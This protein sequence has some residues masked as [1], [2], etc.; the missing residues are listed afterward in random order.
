MPLELGPGAHDERGV[1]RDADHLDA[2]LLRDGLERVE[3]ALASAVG[4]AAERRGWNASTTLLPLREESDLVSKPAPMSVK[5][6]RR[7]RPR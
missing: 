4:V 5:S 1:A 3:L 6:G 7:R 2:V